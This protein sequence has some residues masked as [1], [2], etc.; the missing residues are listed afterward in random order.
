MSDFGFVPAWPDELKEL[1]RK[2]YWA[3]QRVRNLEAYIERVDPDDFFPLCQNWNTL[4]L[5][6]VVQKMLFAVRGKSGIFPWTT[7]LNNKSYTDMRK[8][9]EHGA[10]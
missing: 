1:N 6:A 3:Q 4:L 9:P 5:S 7:R 10:G 2:Y 8:A